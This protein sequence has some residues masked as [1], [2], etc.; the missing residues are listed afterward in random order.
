MI[1]GNRAAVDRAIEICKEKGAKRALPLPVSVP[2]HCALMRPAAEELAERLATITLHTPSIKVVNNVDVAV[3]TAPAT[4]REAL[5][6]QL[7][8]PVRWTESVRLLAARGVTGIVECGPGKVLA[9]LNRR[10]EKGMSVI[11]VQD[12]A[13]LAEAVAATT[14]Q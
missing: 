10:I 12:S 5:V 14:E 13:G 8:S 3:E 9:G 2:S 11:A 1:A 4:I 6:R 7:H